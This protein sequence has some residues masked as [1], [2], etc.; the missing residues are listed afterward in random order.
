MRPRRS[1]T[2]ATAEAVLG[3]SD[4]FVKDS[5]IF[6]ESLKRRIDREDTV[7]FAK[8]EGQKSKPG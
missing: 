7:L 1:A 3:A 2:G 8:I 5:T 4:K 6:F